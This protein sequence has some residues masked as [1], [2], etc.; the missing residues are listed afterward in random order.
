M[1]VKPMNSSERVRAAAKDA[2]ESDDAD[3]LDEMFAVSIS[4]GEYER[5]HNTPMAV[6]TM[7]I[8]AAS[9]L[10]MDEKIRKDPLY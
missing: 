6:T 3:E 2:L 5:A 9:S 7:K 8:S 1:T 10:V 4:S